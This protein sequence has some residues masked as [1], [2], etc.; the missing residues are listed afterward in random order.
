[1][2]LGVVR[3]LIAHARRQALWVN[4]IQLALGGHNGA[5]NNGANIGNTPSPVAGHPATR[6]GGGDF[7]GLPF[8]NLFNVDDRNDFA[9]RIDR[10]IER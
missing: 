8:M 9:I 4:L 5:I 2:G 7:I 6:A 1:M 3:H 10:H